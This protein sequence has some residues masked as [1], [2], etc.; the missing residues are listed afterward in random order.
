MTFDGG[1]FECPDFGGRF[2]GALQCF[3]DKCVEMLV[4]RHRP[5]D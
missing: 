3:A 1:K 2:S 5:N 4:T